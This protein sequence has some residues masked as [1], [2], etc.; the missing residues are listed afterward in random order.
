MVAMKNA[1]DNALEIVDELT[2][3]YNQARQTKI[4]NEL[5]DVISARMALE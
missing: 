2:L 5:L 4:T 1:N 3:E